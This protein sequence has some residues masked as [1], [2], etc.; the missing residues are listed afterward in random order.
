MLFHRYILTNKYNLYDLTSLTVGRE[1]FPISF[2]KSRPVKNPTVIKVKIPVYLILNKKSDNINLVWIT[3][4]NKNLES[5]NKQSCPPS[6]FCR[7][8][9]KQPFLKYTVFAMGQKALSVYVCQGDSSTLTW[10]LN[11]FS[12]YNITLNQTLRSQEYRKWS[13][14]NK[15]SSWILLM[16]TLWYVSRTVWRICILML[17]CKG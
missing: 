3:Y 10:D 14:T 11:P 5:Q 1:W 17:G 12:P 15:R 7:T 8:N 2:H 6:G 9:N 13:P 16:S 4:N